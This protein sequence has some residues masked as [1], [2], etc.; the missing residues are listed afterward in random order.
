MDGIVSSRAAAAA[1]W[2]T[3]GVNSYLVEVGPGWDAARVSASR[4]GCVR[5]WRVVEEIGWC[6]THACPR[7]SLWTGRE[8]GQHEMGSFEKYSDLGADMVGPPPAST[9]FQC[10]GRVVSSSI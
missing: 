2:C 9:N 7:Q 1:S 8:D 4:E 5:V 6:A 10:S 3:S